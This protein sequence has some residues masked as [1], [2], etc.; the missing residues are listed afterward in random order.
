MVSGS[1]AA[2]AGGFARLP[3]LTGLRWLAA[4]M[5][6]GFHLSVVSPTSNEALS[7]L[8]RAVKMGGIGVSFFFVLSGFVLVWSYRP[9]DTTRAFLRRR[10]AKIYPNYAFALICALIVLAVTGEVIDKWSVLTNVLLINS[11]ILHDG[12]PNAINPVAWTLCCEAFFYLSLP[13]VLPRL[14]RL[15]TERLY[16][17][18]AVLPLAALLVNNAAREGLPS[19]AAPYFGFFPPTRYQEFLVGVIVGVLVI[20]GR[21]AGPRLWPSTALVVTTYTAHSWVDI[22]VVVP[23]AFAALIAAATTADLDG[24]WSPWRWRPIVVLGEVSYAFYLVHF[25]VLTT[26]VQV[27]A[28]LDPDRSFWF[29]EQPLLGGAGL[30]TGGTMAIALLISFPMYYWLERPMM[31]A[32]GGRPAAARPEP[33]VDAAS[34]S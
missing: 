28:R 13:F 14:Q 6:W 19:Q 4:F 18:L 29:G 30:F 12:Y 24:R 23:V 9:N 27:L 15:S 3:S 32:L 31:R 20:R 21:W 10:F 22:S 25:L 34:R 1:K 33:A 2:A 16:V 7:W 17:W 5:V 8:F 11:W 26:A